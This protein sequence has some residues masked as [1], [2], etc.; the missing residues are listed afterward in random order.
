MFN[1]SR[2]GASSSTSNDLPVATA[3]AATAEDEALAEA[4]RRSVAPPLNA[5]PRMA[6][7]M[8]TASGQVSSQE[9]DTLNS[10][11]STSTAPTSTDN[12]E[13]GWAC[14]MCTFE[15][16]SPA[17]ECALCQSPRPLPTMPSAVPQFYE[18]A[19]AFKHN[20]SQQS[21]QGANR[22][23]ADQN[24]LDLSAFLTTYARSGP[25]NTSAHGT[26][27][28]TTARLEGVLVAPDGARFSVGPLEAPTSALHEHLDALVAAGFGLNEHN[29]GDSEFKS[30]DQG[31]TKAP[32]SINT[33]LL[34]PKQ[35]V[36][37][38]S[39]KDV[40][41]SKNSLPVVNLDGTIAGANA[42]DFHVAQVIFNL[43]HTFLHISSVFQT[44]CV[45]L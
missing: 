9:I 12:N 15:N 35:G 2:R 29:T 38:T 44:L 13:V 33:G 40:N 37:Q 26:Y 16:P 28:N 14:E 39:T 32:L 19:D 18:T 43:S 45:F 8:G 34:T 3:T 22:G 4:L 1:W 11:A 41:D 7:Q 23:V 31:S 5:T 17:P 30:K 6:S 21:R 25:T 20:A 42:D 36:S 10:D 24:S 27:A